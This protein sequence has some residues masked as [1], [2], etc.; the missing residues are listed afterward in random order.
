[1]G[2]V[3]LNDPSRSKIAMRILWLV[4]WYPNKTEP[5]AGD[6]I[7]RHAEAVS[8]FHRVDVIHVVRDARGVLTR[9]SHIEETGRD[10]LTEKLIYY[11]SRPLPFAGRF[12]SHIKYKRIFKNCIREYVAEKGKPDIIHVHVGMKAG[13]LAVWAKKKLGVPYVV[14]EHWSGFVPNADRKFSDLPGW[15]RVGWRKVMREASAISAVS[16]CLATCLRD[17]FKLARPVTIIANVVNTG[18][19]SRREEPGNGSTFIHVSALNYQKNAEDILRAFAMVRDKGM[20]FSLILVGPEQA[21]IRQ[22]VNGL[23]LA[24]HVTLYPEMPQPELADLVRRSDAM[25]L[26]SRFETFGCVI[27]EA[28]ATGVPVLVSDLPVFHEIV[29]E[30]VNGVFVK[31]ESPDSLA[32]SISDFLNGKYD[33]NPS[34]ISRV[35]NKKFGYEVVGRQF[36]EWYQSIL[37]MPGGDTSSND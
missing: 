23:G 18:I 3:F 11:F 17:T 15:M 9:Y 10:R 6:F 2:W 25:I 1:M 4:S 22:L 8:L 30:G 13:R 26:Y 20:S 29:E 5:F 27:I 32:Q 28:N 36:A 37:K 35:A 34:L 19:F 21:G 33:F 7:K 31:G 12:L 14:T 16:A 24:D